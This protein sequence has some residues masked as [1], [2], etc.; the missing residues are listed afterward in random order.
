MSGLSPERASAA[1][2]LY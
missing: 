1:A 2:L